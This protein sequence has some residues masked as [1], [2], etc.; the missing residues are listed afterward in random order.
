M[1]KLLFTIT[2]LAVAHSLAA[3]A[4]CSNTS[5][6]FTPINDLGTGTFNNYQGSLY[7]NGSNY[8]PTQH[9]TDGMLLANQVQPLDANGNPDAN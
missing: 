6:G 1:K 8:M 7:P 5:V 9:K 3:Q 2:C 4:N